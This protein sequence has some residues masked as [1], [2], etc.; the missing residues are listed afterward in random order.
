MVDS[1]DFFKNLRSFKLF[2]QL[3]DNSHFQAAPEDW[4]VIITD[5]KGSTIA[6][7]E[8]RYKDVNTIGAATIITILNAVTDFE[9]PFVFGG[10]GATVL[11]PSEY[12]SKIGAALLG[13]KQLSINNFALELRTGIVSVKEVLNKGG[14]IEVAKHALESGKSIALFRGG[15]LT[16]AENLIKGD[17][18]K[19]ELQ[20]EVDEA[21]L[22]GLSCRWQNIPNKRGQILSLLVVARD[23]Q[24]DR[25]YRD[26]LKFLNKTI[27]GQIANA[28]PVNSNEMS[29][30]SFWRCLKD[31]KRFLSSIFSKEF[32]R[33]IVD[34][35]I[36]MIIFKLRVPLKSFD[37]K[38]YIKSIETHSDYRK[39]DDM[40]R[41]IL[42][43]SHAEVQSIEKYFAELYQQQKIFYGL[44]CSDTS[45]M[46]CFVP[47]VSD[48]KH[49]HFIDGGDGGYAMAAKQLKAQ[50]KKC[51]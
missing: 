47:D 8:G 17:E 42:D 18:A 22:N 5:V 10:D 49:I 4:F 23:G 41:M 48:G 6:I 43:C 2:S 36:S 15:G 37:T 34:I 32:L 33:R 31:E 27:K 50:M 35:F 14:V 40:L 25:V 26:I 51:Q 24:E 19:Y 45:L 12:V 39:F 46:T 1:R 20:G 7:E 44:F 11:I 21:N 13:L 38:G 28:N 9:F 30:K 3:V 16:I 29:Y